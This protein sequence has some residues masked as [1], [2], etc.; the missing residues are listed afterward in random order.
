MTHTQLL[1]SVARMRAP[2]PGAS[3]TGPSI[4]YEPVFAEI[5]LAREADDPSL[6]LGEWER[7]LKKSDWGQVAHLC[8]EVLETQSKDLQIASWLVE[9]WTQLHGLDG[10]I[11]GTTLLCDLLEVYWDT[12]HPELDADDPEPR[13]A[14]LVWL[15]ENLP[16]T[17]RLH[18]AVLHWPERKPPIISLDN[19][20][21]TLT[22]SPEETDEDEDAPDESR[23]PTREA[24][25]RHAAGPAHSEL[26][27]RQTQLQNALMSWAQLDDILDS[28]LGVQAPSLARVKTTLE[29]MA[30]A[31]GSLL[32]AG[33]R[34]PVAQVQAPAGSA[35]LPPQ[36]AEPEHPLAPVTANTV[37]PTLN[38]AA[39]TSRAEAYAQL[40]N[41]A[42]YL[43]HIEPHSPTPYLIRRAVSWGRMPLPELM[44]E[45]LREEGD[46]NRLFTV[47]GLKPN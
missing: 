36:S 26:L 24:M 29:H 25:L 13:I 7:P 33:V 43:Q 41:I 22:V 14:P 15:N 46:L 39:M 1:E 11:A 31:I 8:C 20:T 2:L 30:R 37:L 45:V 38:H 9:A 18:V 32:A 19:W 10:L 6:P 4:R 40:E 47:L 23:L 21:Q 3:P 44:Q 5:R 42:N 27:A 17:L 28:H 35:F 16:L 12:L 34:E